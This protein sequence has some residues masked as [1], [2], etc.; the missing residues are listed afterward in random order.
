MLHQP[1]QVSTVLKHTVS[2]SR[3]NQSSIE[4]PGVPVKPPISFRDGCAHEM[5]FKR[6][7]EPVFCLY[8]AS[9]SA[10]KFD[11]VTRVEGQ[12]VLQC[13][14]SITPTQHHPLALRYINTGTP[15][16]H[17]IGE[18]V[19]LALGSS[20]ASKLNVSIFDSNRNHFLTSQDLNSYLYLPAA[21]LAKAFFV[22][23]SRDPKARAAAMDF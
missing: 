1:D 8:P 9:F 3:K 5:T 14:W 21:V 4:S 11:W 17:V 10:P 16:R 18:T 7:S 2:D 12:Q 20:D 23:F 13:D 15:L 22:F 6:I 19:I